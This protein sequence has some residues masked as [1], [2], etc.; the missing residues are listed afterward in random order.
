MSKVEIT[1]WRKSYTFLIVSLIAGI[2][3]LVYVGKY[4]LVPKMFLSKVIIL[5]IVVFLLIP[6]RLWKRLLGYNSYESI[7]F[8]TIGLGLNFNTFLMWLNFFCVSNTYS[9]EK[10]IVDMKIQQD[11][12][13]GTYVEFVLEDDYLKEFPEVRIFDVHEDNKMLLEAQK[14]KY[15]ITTGCLGYDVVK[16]IEAIN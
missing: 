5:N 11:V 2:G 14:L 15:T 13:A 8:A 1:S 9:E 7:L 10:H 4:T 3:T 6:I 12:L 16:N